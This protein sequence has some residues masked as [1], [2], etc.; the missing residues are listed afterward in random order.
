MGQREQALAGYQHYLKV[1][2]NGPY[3]VPAL[4]ALDRLAH[5]RAEATSP[6]S[7]TPR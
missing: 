4:L 1:D 6:P 5:T 3:S 7:Q 2:P